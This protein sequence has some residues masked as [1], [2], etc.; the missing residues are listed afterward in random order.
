M[1]FAM[2]QPDHYRVEYEINPWMKGNA[3]KVDPQ[4]AIRQWENYRAKLSETARVDVIPS[5]YNVPD[6]VFAANGAFVLNNKAII[7]NFRHP[8]RQE[9]EEHFQEWLQ[10]QQF[11]VYRLPKGLAFEGAGDGIIDTARGL[12]WFGY[13]F[14]TNLEAHRLVAAILNHPVLSLRLVDERFYHLDTCFAPLSSGHVLY[15]PE[16]FDRASIQVIEAHVPSDKRIAV[17]MAD[18]VALACNC[19]ESGGRVFLSSCSEKLQRQIEAAG[20]E[21]VRTELGEFHKSGGSNRCLV[22]RL[23]DELPEEAVGEQALPSREVHVS[24]HLIDRGILSEVFN[25]INESGGGFEMLEFDA[26]IRTHDHSFARIRISAPTHRALEA[27]LEQLLETGA[28]IVNKMENARLETVEQDGVAPADFY[29][30]TIYN[31]EVTV[32]GETVAVEN[33]RMDATIVVSGKGNGTGLRAE[34]RLMRDLRAGDRVV[35]GIDGVQTHAPR[36]TAQHEEFLFMGGGVSSERRVETSVDQIA[37]EMTRIRARGGR[38]VVTAGPVIVHT[39]GVESMCELIEM[40]YVQALLGGNA[41]AVHDIERDLFGTSLGVDLDRGAI[42]E[43]GH[44]HHLRA[45]NEIRRYGSIAAAVEQGAIRSGIMKTLVDSGVP[46]VLAGS[47]RD[48]GPLPD[49]LMDLC[50]AQRQYQEQLRGADMVL[51]LSSML[52][53]IGTANMVP[54]GVRLVCV[55]INP[56]VATKLSD[57]G[58]LESVGLVT[59]VSLFLKLLVQKLHSLTAVKV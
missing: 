27:I 55:D 46:F 47:I 53:A 19:V 7:S 28:H 29:C 39:G 57:R 17:D 26:G 51:L 42:I 9:E 49:T 31:T 44:R 38:I 33:Q 52:H 56:A 48:D 24:G 13:G 30:S 20:F 11:E 25:R 34:C 35:V 58:S 37:W 4:A 15:F 23:H 6:M 21:V 54:S 18:A 50:E 5:Q 2:V 36:H 14:R 59:D 41:I 3:H 45:I 12:L 16:A 8:E 22:L 32:E 1:R 40:G 10:S 43:G